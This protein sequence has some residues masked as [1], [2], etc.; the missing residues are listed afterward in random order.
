MLQPIINMKTETFNNSRKHFISQVD[1]Y[2]QNTCGLSY[3]D[4]P[5]TVFIDDFWYEQMSESEFKGA[6]ADCAMEILENAGYTAEE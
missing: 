5:D 3:H 1:S 4:L 6:V 2:C